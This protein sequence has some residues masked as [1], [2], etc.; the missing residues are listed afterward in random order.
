[1]YFQVKG[2]EVIDNP[3]PV[4]ATLPVC[5]QCKRF[6]EDTGLVDMVKVVNWQPIDIRTIVSCFH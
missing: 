3:K 6:S 5:H 2:T 4:V 1:M